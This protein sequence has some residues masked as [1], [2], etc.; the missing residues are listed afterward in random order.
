[1]EKTSESK[2][3]DDF[4]G[5][6]PSGNPRYAVYDFEYQKGDEGIRNK[7]CFYTWSVSYCRVWHEGSISERAWLLI[8]LLF[9][10]VYMLMQSVVSNRN[11]DDARIKQKMV[12]ASSKDALRKSLVG[13][14]T[15]IQGTDLSE[16]A[17][18]T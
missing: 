5:D 15:E 2:D 18:D 16:V 9:L 4:I 14:S 8:W 12:Y 10:H 13:I 3:Y 17:Y 7:L 1:M 11:P 6:L